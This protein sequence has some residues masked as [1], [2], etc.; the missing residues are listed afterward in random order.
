MVC[1]Y[2]VGARSLASSYKERQAEKAAEERK[3]LRQEEERRRREEEKQNSLVGRKTGLR[4]KS[5]RM[6]SS[7][8]GWTSAC[9]HVCMVQGAR[10]GASFGYYGSELDRAARA[11]SSARMS[12]ACSWTG[13]RE[14]WHTR[15]IRQHG[16]AQGAASA[17]L[18]VLT[19]THHTCSTA[20]TTW[21]S[22]DSKVKTACSMPYRHGVCTAPAIRTY[23]ACLPANG[24]NMHNTPRP[25]HHAADETVSHSG[26]RRGA[27]C[28]AIRETCSIPQSRA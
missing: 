8:C 20:G 23:T 2:S 15:G 18:S 11:S 4:L 24:W 21:Q 3:K 12:P 22:L 17:C 10:R 19:T 5:E 7:L 14:K 26:R 1:R 25:F 9:V 6:D 27:G 16:R 13:K 28:C